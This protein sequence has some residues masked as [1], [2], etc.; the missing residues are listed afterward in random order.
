M[1][2][3]VVMEIGNAQTDLFGVVADHGFFQGP[4]LTENVIQT[5]TYT[6]QISKKER[7]TVESV[8]V[9]HMR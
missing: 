6:V 1:E 3:M 7:L 4:K 9:V 8:L 5:T 2:D